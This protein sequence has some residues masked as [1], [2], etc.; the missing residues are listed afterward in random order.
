MFVAR[1]KCGPGTRYLGL[2]LYFPI[3]QFRYSILALLLITVAT[4][5]AQRRRP[6]RE[7]GDGKTP[8]TVEQ[9][10][11]SAEENEAARTTQL[12]ADWTE[13][14]ESHYRKQDRATRKRMRKNTRRQKQARQGRLIPWWQRIFGKT[15]RYQQ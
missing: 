13:A 7:G 5:D 2:S 4:A 10:I 3:M 8:R 12:H 6:A 14:K 15:N 1:E 9:S 11:R